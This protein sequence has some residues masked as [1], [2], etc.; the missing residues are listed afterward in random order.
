MAH[1]CA[2][3]SGKSHLPNIRQFYTYLFICIG[4]VNIRSIFTLSDIIPDLL[5]VWERSYILSHILILPPSVYDSLEFGSIF[6]EDAEHW[7]GLRHISLL[8][9][10]STFISLDFIDELCL[11]CIRTLR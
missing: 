5:L 10:S 8:P 6:L 3:Y 7:G 1:K 11:E 9:P 2:I 4:H